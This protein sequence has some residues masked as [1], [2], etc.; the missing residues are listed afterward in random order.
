M[1]RLLVIPV[2]LAVTG[3]SHWSADAYNGQAA[4]YID[5]QLTSGM[6]MAEVRRS[7]PNAMA[8]EPV[9]GTTRYLVYV[10]APCFQCAS[11]SGFKRSS[12]IYARVLIFREDQLVVIESVSANGT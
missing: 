9:A 3:C 11:A 5:S 4:T 12:E 7:F 6:S 1:H 2:L 10:E 8:L